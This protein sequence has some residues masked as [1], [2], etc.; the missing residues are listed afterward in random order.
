[1]FGFSF[2]ANLFSMVVLVCLLFSLLFW[3]KE[4][5]SNEMLHTHE[6]LIHEHTHTHD[7]EH[8]M[9]EHSEI[10]EE[11]SHDHEHSEIT[12]EHKFFI[13]I[14]HQRWPK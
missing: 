9:H 4:E 1:M 14:H 2:T 11:H 12:H 5:I 8:H 7:D 10:E 6:R 13:D 3:P